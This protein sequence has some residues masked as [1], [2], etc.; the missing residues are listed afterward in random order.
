[1][2]DFRDGAISITIDNF[3]LKGGLEPLLLR[4]L[5][6]LFLFGL[7]ARAYLGSL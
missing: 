7:A 6:A 2:Q 3:R 5:V 1:M 4:V